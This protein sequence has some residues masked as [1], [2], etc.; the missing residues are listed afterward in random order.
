[1]L[2]WRD[3]NRVNC[4]IRDF[5]E[6]TELQLAYISPVFEACILLLPILLLPGSRVCIL[7]HIHCRYSAVLWSTFL[8]VNEFRFT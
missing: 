5:P 1:M 6:T 2:S 3:A 8:L 7:P 4:K